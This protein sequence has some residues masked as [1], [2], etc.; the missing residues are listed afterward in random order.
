MVFKALEKEDPPHEQVIFCSDREAGLKALIAI[1]SS[2]LGPALGGCRMYPYKTE[3]AAL[4]D[5]LRL[6]RAMSYKAAIAGLASGG[7]KSV[8]I[9]DPDKDK[10][11]ALLRAFGRHVQALEG[12]YIAAKDMGI[13]VE[14][15]R[16]VAEETHY[17]LGRPRQEGGVGDPSPSTAKGVYYGMKAAV[18]WKL[19]KDSLKGLRVVVQGAG[20]V[21]KKLI[22]LLVKDSAEVWVSEIRE[23]ALG[24]LKK[25]FPSV[26][27]IS[28]E[29]SLSSPCD[30]FAPCALGGIINKTSLSVLDCSLIAG[31]ANNQLSSPSLGQKLAEKG[32]LYIPDFAIN[33]GGLI[34]VYSCLKPGKSA[35]WVES[36]VRE[37]P[38]TI[39]EICE[40]AEK[41]GISTTETALKL[42]KQRMAKGLK[43]G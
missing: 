29:E 35:E 8:I 14:D 10:S 1:H 21:G 9:G 23:R 41:E 3:R 24:D 20:A 2:V 38:K 28:P 31:G 33:S 6:S 36:K 12:R 25:D 4:K 26:R 34:Y 42:A 39:R 27:V 40:Y 11:P 32:I 17:V 5:V 19:K 22:E 16:C 13:S 30:I 37:I 7:G 43:A 18:K 15:L